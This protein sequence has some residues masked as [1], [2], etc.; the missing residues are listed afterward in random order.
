MKASFHVLT[1][2]LNSPAQ[3]DLLREAIKRGHTVG[4]RF[5]IG[6]VPNSMSENE[7]IATL[8]A[9]SQ[10]FHDVFG[11]YPR[12]LR[13]PWQQFNSTSVTLAQRMGFIV[14][15]WNLDALDYQ[16]A[17]F[18]QVQ[19]FVRSQIKPEAGTISIHRDI[20]PIYNETFAFGMMLDTISSS[21]RLNVVG[22]DK[23]L[24]QTQ[25]WRTNN[26]DP[27][28]LDLNG[29]TRKSTSPSP[30]LNPDND[31]DDDKSKSTSSAMNGKSNNESGKFSA[32][33]LLAISLLALI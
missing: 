18:L 1:T 16:A 13:F 25:L 8:V 15:A 2:R 28:V 4:L 33:I 5:P 27:R 14:S 26:R 20:Y 3:V 24:G 19:T 7:L 23:C 31:D 17:S 9:E 22:L 10:A 11:E 30:T 12:F 32:L 6:K 21:L 29:V